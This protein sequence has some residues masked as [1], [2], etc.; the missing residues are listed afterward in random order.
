MNGT[1]ENIEIIDGE[2]IAADD[3]EESTIV[4]RRANRPPS[5]VVADKIRYW[6]L[7]TIFWTVALLGGFRIGAGN[8]EFVFV[9]PPLFC[10]IAAAILLVLF[11]RSGLLSVGGWFSE[12]F[13]ATK[14]IAN[15]AVIASLFAA[16]VQLFNSLLP[17]AGLPF[18]VVGFCFF[19]TLWNNLFAE[20][21]VRR[22]IR[23]LGALF[24]LAFVVK[25][26][27]LL[28]LTAPVADSWW[29]GMFQNPAKE[30]ATW[31]LS[32]PRYG[33]ATGYVQFFTVIFF[34]IGLFLLRPDSVSDGQR[35]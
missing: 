17:E 13:S 4:R 6:L 32:L 28:N 16:S 12:K 33:G 1:G 7:P 26:L 31:L 34:L 5:S 30:S 18:Y 2:L 27:I 19:W 3:A 20:F 15:A 29:S 25:Y 8:G 14:N 22:L 35:V 10:L 24:G 21:D 23:S 11:F 9:A